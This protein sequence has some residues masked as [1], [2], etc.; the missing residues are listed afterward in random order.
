MNVKGKVI[1]S[2]LV[3][4]TVIVVFWEYINSPEA[5]FLWIYHSKNPEV[6]DSS[7]Q[8]GWWFLSWFNNGIHNYQQREE[9][10]DKEKG[11]E[12]TKERKMT[13]Q[14]FGYGTGLIQNIMGITWRSS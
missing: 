14:S 13:Q 11:R 5:S 10:I 4:S 12:E 2:M 6:D 3:V 9:D 8:K 1:L 7:A